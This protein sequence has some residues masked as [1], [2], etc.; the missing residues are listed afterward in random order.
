[1]IPAEYIMDDVEAD[2]VAM[3]NMIY[4][5]YPDF[6]KIIE[7]LRKIEVEVHSLSK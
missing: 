7:C 2:Y 5:D 4:G 6:N 3:K 1:M